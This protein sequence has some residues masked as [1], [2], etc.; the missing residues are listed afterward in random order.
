M[1]GETTPAGFPAACFRRPRSAGSSRFS[2]S[3]A[4]WFSYSAARSL[5]SLQAASSSARGRAPPPPPPARFRGAARPPRKAWR[6][7]GRHVRSGRISYAG[8]TTRRSSSSSVL[9]EH[10]PLIVSHPQQDNLL[11][12]PRSPRCIPGTRHAHAPQTAN[13]RN[14]KL[15]TASRAG[16]WPRRTRSRAR[17]DRR[18]PAGGAG[19]TRKAAARRLS[20]LLTSE[21]TP[22]LLA[23]SDSTLN[24]FQRPGAG[25]R[26]WR[27]ADLARADQGAA[28]ALR[29]CGWPKAGDSACWRWLALAPEAEAGRPVARSLPLGCCA[30]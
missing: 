12:R 29:A 21:S 26:G 11:C 1:T 22:L 15:R 20:F 8:S 14:S 28:G 2:R 25:T 5:H 6:A 19:A 13:T 17:P 24:W 16:P 10:T 18:P 30:V 4:S 9:C 3:Q 27:G 7:Q 23:A